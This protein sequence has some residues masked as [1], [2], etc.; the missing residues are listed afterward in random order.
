[1]HL[2]PIANPQIV[3]RFF[4]LDSKRQECIL[5]EISGDEYIACDEA[6]RNFWASSK[7]GIYGTGLL[8]SADDPCR[9]ERIGLLGQA[10]FSKL[11]DEPVD[12]EY[13]RGGDKQDNLV[14]GHRIDV[15]CAA[16]N[17]GANL[18][19]KT[20]EFGREQKIDKHYYVGAF[21]SSED[22]KEKIAKIILVGFSSQRDVLAAKVSPAIRG[23]HI[24][25]VIPFK[26]MRPIEELITII[27]NL[28]ESVC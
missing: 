24:N 11:I 7:G 4:S 28:K 15:K 23:N 19:Q 17:Y 10:A 9:T 12:L 8:N 2:L 3:E 26:E 13:R 22:R 6:S 20:N 14:C 5:V 1:M 25:Y 16:R 18:I 27:K 21:L